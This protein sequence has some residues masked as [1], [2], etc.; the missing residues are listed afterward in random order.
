V[1][2]AGGTEVYSSSLRGYSG[3]QNYSTNL[4]AATTFQ[5]VWI[6]SKL[7]SGTIY[8]SASF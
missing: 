3:D 2:V 7:G 6:R 5:A 8:G 4:T 1:L